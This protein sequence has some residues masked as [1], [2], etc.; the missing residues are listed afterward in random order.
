MAVSAE[1]LNIILSARDKEFTKAMARSQRR[2]EMFAKQSQKGLSKTGQSFDHIGAIA[3][4][5]GPQLAAA[6][7]V[8]AIGN[9]INGAA[10]IANLSK[11]AGVSTD[12]FQILAATT[13]KFGIGS[14]KLSDILKDV[15]D[16]F[17]DFT[18]TG[19]GPLKDFFEFIAPKV[20]LTADAFADM[21]S[22]QKLGAYVNALEKANVSQSEMTFYM[23]A[24]ASDS[25]ALVAAFTENGAA[26]DAMRSK[27]DKLGFVLDSAL[28]ERATEAKGELS[29]MATVIKANL[30]QVLIELAPILVGA[31]TGFAQLVSA[32]VTAI[33]SVDEFIN[34]QTDLQVATD[35]LVLAMADEINQSQ[36]LEIALGR[37]TNMSVDAAKKKLS[38]AQARYEN[39]KAAIAEQRAIA[40]G[41][42]AYTG[43]LSEIDNVRDAIKTMAAPREDDTTMAMRESY[44][45]LQQTLV[46]LLQTQQNMLAADENLSEHYATTASNIETLETALA[47]VENGMVSFG[48]S[49]VTPIAATDRLAST[50]GRAAANVAGLSVEVQDIAPMLAQ[51]GLEADQIDGIMGSVQSSMED[52]FMGMVDGT[53]SAKDAFKTMAADIIKELYRVL[54]VQ[55]LVGSFEKGSG[56]ILGAAF[57]ALG[58]KASGGSVMAG[59]AYTVGE[60]GR[61]PFIPS[62]NGRILSTAQAKSAMSG[63]G[64]SG[65][66]IIQNNTFGNGVNRAEINAMLPKIVEA[67]KAAVLDARRRGGSYAGAF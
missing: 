15:N 34:P 42:E 44:E 33:K 17:G 55:R 37:S 27:A 50:A 31:A 18:Q 10:E 41:S 56:G 14:E 66:T 51:L 19:A 29:L 5:L 59:Q 39:A 26:I 25:T 40:L 38:E 60:H 61:E 7:S 4:K 9:V 53:M 35:N 43:V 8:A 2:V 20:N 63:G 46:G 62:Q 21:S 54:V 67:S 47:D 57:T 24:I 64:G 11:I 49:I 58:G 36:Q 32:I 45:G 12:E 23:E 28:I 65:V 3:K 30:S 22:D 16:K 48:D 6:F 1:Q 13:T 52:A